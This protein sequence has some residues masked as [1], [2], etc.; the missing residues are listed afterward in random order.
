MADK[1][2]GSVHVPFVVR[3]GQVGRVD[4]DTDQPGP[5]DPD[6]RGRLDVEPAKIVQV[7]P[8]IL[9][10]FLRRDRAV[11]QSLCLDLVVVKNSKSR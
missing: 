1:L 11:G 10:D 9:G 7:E 3:I 2:D 5:M 8:S 4:Q 6:N